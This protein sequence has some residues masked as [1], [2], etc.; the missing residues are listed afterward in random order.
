MKTKDNAKKVSTSVLP[1][2]KAMVQ[3]ANERLRSW[4]YDVFYGPI[5]DNTG[6]L[7]IDAGESM[8]DDEMLNG[9]DWYVEGVAVEG[10][11]MGGA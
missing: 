9:F 1:R 3:E 5:R 4:E 2:T 11:G 7:R 10:Q 8:T 6:R